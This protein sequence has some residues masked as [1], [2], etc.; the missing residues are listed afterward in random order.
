MLRLFGKGH[1][2]TCFVFISIELINHADFLII[3][4]AIFRDFLHQAKVEFQNI[5]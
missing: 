5:C 4:R 3:I 2:S 1:K